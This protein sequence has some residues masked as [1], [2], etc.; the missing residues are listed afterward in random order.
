MATTFTSYTKLAKPAVADRNWNVPLNANADQLDGLAPLGGLC[1]TPAE[2]PSASLNVQVAPGTYTKPDGTAGAY[3]GLPSVAIGPGQTTVLYLTAGGTL[4]IA[5]TGYPGTAHVRLAT[6]TSGTG[7]ILGVHDDRITCSVVG[8]DALPYLPLAGGTL[9]D[10]AGVA[11]G[12]TTGTQLGTATTQRLGFWGAT[13]VTRPGPY[14][15]VYM[16]T[17]RTLMAYTPIVESTAFSGIAT[18]QA[19]SPYAQ[20]SDLNS[21]RMAYENLR[22]LTENLAQVVNSLM[23]DLRSMGLIG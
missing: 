5:T 13:P 11:L 2:V 20:A 10:G 15:Q 14:T 12:T 8:S 16:A 7:T 18:G 17:A 9:G 19:G 23:N 6:V 22:Q 1:V 3:A 4:T 21:L